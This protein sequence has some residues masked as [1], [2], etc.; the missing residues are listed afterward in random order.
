MAITHGRSLEDI[1]I[2]KSLGNLPYTSNISLT[3]FIE[4]LTTTWKLVSP[5]NLIAALPHGQLLVADYVSIASTDAN[6]NVLGTGARVISLTGVDENYD[7]YQELIL[8]Q[9]QTP[10]QTVNKMIPFEMIVLQYGSNV[11]SI[12]DSTSVGSI[13]C[14]TGTFTLGIPSN[15]IVAILP[16]SADPNSRDAI[17]VVPD[18][19]V[20]L[21][22]GMLVTAD[23][24]KNENT[25]AIVQIALRLFGFGDNQWFKTIPFFFD[26]V[27]YV[28]F[29]NASPLPP[30][31]Q[32]QIRCRSNV[33]KTKKVSVSFDFELKDLR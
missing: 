28:V 32:L 13:Y 9:G 12:E 30:R 20:L 22:K 16:T 23:P 1:R 21:L 18:G 2:Q 14:G 15:P 11:N 19:K 10:V 24:D 29:E 27:G 25:S 8:M 6:D 7:I 33:L 5:S 4:D 17:F 26:G 31:T 3:G